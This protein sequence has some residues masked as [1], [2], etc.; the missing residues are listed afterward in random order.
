[1]TT[2][3]SRFSIPSLIKDHHRRIRRLEASP[4]DGGGTGGGACPDCV[5]DPF[6]VNPGD[7]F[8]PP[9]MRECTDAAA[10]TFDW[11]TVCGFNGVPLG[12]ADA[13]KCGMYVLGYRLQTR[14]RIFF[15]N[16]GDA[17]NFE[18]VPGGTTV[19]WDVGESP[20]FYDT[21]WVTV[22]DGYCS[23]CDD[24]ITISA[25]FFAANSGFGDCSTG[26][27]V[28]WRWVKVDDDGDYRGALDELPQGEAFGDVIYFDPVA[29]E[30]LEGPRSIPSRA[31]STF[32][33]G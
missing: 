4:G 9:E 18:V 15:P 33:G 7:I 25:S 19:T 28:F 16:V 29:H 20:L 5:L 11:E 14:G 24:D 6:T 21:G 12:S 23:E 3:Q 13:G 22:D 17:E 8:V 2:P 27:D 32:M 31:I 10:G 30:F 1:M 26:G